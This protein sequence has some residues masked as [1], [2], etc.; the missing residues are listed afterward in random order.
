MMEFTWSDWHWGYFAFYVVLGGALYHIIKRDWSHD[1]DTR[2][3]TSRLFEISGINVL[4]VLILIAMY[5]DHFHVAK[6]WY[7]I[8]LIEI[9]VGAYAAHLIAKRY[10]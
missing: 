9:G 8:S 2:T 3:L 1:S 6:A 7:G 10:G 5:H 4:L